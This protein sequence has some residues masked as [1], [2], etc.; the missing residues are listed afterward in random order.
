MKKIVG[1]VLG[2]I[3][4]LGVDWLTKYLAYVHLGDRSIP[5]IGEFLQLRYVENTGMA[6]GS[7]AGN[8]AVTTLVPVACMIVLTAACFYFGYYFKKRNEEKTIKAIK[9]MFVFYIAGFLGNYVERIVNDRVI[10][11]ISF[12]GFAVFN[13]ADIYATVCQ[14]L[15]IGVMGP[16]AWKYGKERKTQKALEKQTQKNG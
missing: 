13:M 1:Y 11:F 15:L 9:I 16:F 14:V 3:G 6:F 4:L 7:F 10:D 5:I 2:V 12:K 8:E